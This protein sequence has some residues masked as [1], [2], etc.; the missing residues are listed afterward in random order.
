[1]R[2]EKTYYGT[3]MLKMD[4]DL[5]LLRRKVIDVIYQIKDRFPKIPRQTI[6]IVESGVRSDISVCAYAGLSQNY[7]HVTKRWANIECYLYELIAHELVHS[8]TGFEH[9]DNCLLM[10][11]R[12]NSIPLSRDVVNELLDK[13][14]VDYKG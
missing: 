5:Y 12:L 8:V 7:I 10:S 9:D 3:T 14:L 11:P 4:D 1:M 6:R 13:Y 2:K